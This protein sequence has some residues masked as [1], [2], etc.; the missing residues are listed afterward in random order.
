[1]SINGLI[2]QFIKEYEKI[3]SSKP[4]RLFIS[5]EFIDKVKPELIIFKPHFDPYRTDIEI[6]GLPTYVVSN[7]PAYLEVL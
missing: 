7:S 1:M 3:H 5:K 4:S 2:V 6:L